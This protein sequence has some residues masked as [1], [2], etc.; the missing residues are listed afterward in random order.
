MEF[1]SKTTFLPPN[2]E[3]LAASL[4]SAITSLEENLIYK[5]WFQYVC[6]Y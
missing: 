2:Y 5:L 1:L 4:K 3:A 6:S